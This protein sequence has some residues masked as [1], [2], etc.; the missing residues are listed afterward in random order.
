VKG[1]VR[2]D[3]YRLKTSQRK[4]LLGAAMVLLHFEICTAVLRDAV[5]CFGH[6]RATGNLISIDFG[7]VFSF[8]TH[9]R[10]LV[11]LV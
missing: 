8:A 11:L 7:L 6:V 1:G 2:A 10:V 9:L 4:S 5:K 3:T